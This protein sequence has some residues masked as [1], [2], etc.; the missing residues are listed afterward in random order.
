MNFQDTLSK[1]NKAVVK[2]DHISRGFI[3][4]KGEFKGKN[5]RVGIELN[6]CSD[7][8]FSNISNKITV[9]ELNRKVKID[10]LNFDNGAS[11]Y[12]V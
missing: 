2:I 7:V 1:Y 11:Y 10:V 4:F 9:E 3:F 8:Y 5:L 6:A 12:R